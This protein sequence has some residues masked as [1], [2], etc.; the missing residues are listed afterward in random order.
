MSVQ[1][2]HHVN[3]GRDHKEHKESVTG[4]Y[5]TYK[6]N[7]ESSVM[8]HFRDNPCPRKVTFFFWCRTTSYDLDVEPHVEEE[9]RYNQIG[10][11]TF[12]PYQNA[13][14][15]TDSVGLGYTQET[16]E[17]DGKSTC[18]SVSGHPSLPYIHHHLEH[19]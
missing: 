13:R 17:A 2:N 11:F 19:T 18:D 9:R 16:C 10:Y 8:Q 5:D 15:G 1:D 6:C 14:A 3:T 7:M 4:G 12:E